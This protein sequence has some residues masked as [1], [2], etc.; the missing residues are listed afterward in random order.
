MSYVNNYRIY[1]YFYEATEVKAS[2]VISYQLSEMWFV[3]AV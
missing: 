3:L 1:E 2:Y